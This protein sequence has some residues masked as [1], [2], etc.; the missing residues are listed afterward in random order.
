MIHL[1]WLPILVPSVVICVSSQQRR[2]HEGVGAA[3]LG[4]DS[5]SFFLPIEPAHLWHKACPKS[6]A[7]SRI[8][9]PNFIGGVGSLL[10]SFSAADL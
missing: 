9:E 2:K 4:A 6:S 7:V 10:L 8:E 5:T 1:P 3:S